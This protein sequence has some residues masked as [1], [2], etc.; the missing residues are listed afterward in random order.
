MD[1]YFLQ[2]FQRVPERL[3]EIGGNVDYE[4][5]KKKF[6]IHG[7]NKRTLSIKDITVKH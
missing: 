7:L 6:L 3:E 4:R 1:D 2:P 5:V